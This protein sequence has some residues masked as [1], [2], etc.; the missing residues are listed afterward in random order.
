MARWTIGGIDGGGIESPPIRFDANAA[1]WRN[2]QRGSWRCLRGSLTSPDALVL[3][4]ELGRQVRRGKVENQVA[5]V[6]W[7]GGAIGVS[8]RV[9]RIVRRVAKVSLTV[10]C[11]SS[12]PFP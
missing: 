12:H 11:A 9:V 10:R 1:L 5:R 8:D 7:S 4:K 6:L 2:H 3:V